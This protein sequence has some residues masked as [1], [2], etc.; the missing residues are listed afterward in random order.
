MSAKARLLTA[1]ALLLTAIIGVFLYFYCR[2]NFVG[3][4]EK[5]TDMYLMD[6]ASMTGTDSHTLSL[7]S[8]DVLDIQ[9][10]A[11]RGSLHMA[12]TSPDGSVLYEGSGT[13]ATDFTVNIAQSGDYTVNVEARRAEGIIYIHRK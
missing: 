3:V 8:G 12:I 13:E 9:F 2:E 1:A 10:E 11:Q 5:D 7:N 4:C 6:I